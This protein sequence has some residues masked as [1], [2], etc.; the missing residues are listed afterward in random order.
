MNKKK[1]GYSLVLGMFLMN[2]LPLISA[3]GFNF[4]SIS[5]GPQDV[6]QI[7]K[8]FTSPFF[9]ALLNTSAYSEFFFA[10]V[11][12]LILVFV[13]VYFILQK[14]EFL[15]LQ[16]QKGILLIITSVISILALRYLPENDLISGILLPYNA[17]GLAITIFLPFLIY[18]FFV[19]KSVPFS[20]GRR[21][22]WIVYL[23]I[24]GVLWAMRSQELSH[25]ANNIYLFG[26]IAAVLALIFDS[27]IHN[28]FQLGELRK[29]ERALSTQSKV[30]LINEL[31]DIQ[32]ALSLAPN[33][34]DLLKRQAD[35]VKV[36]ERYAKSSSGS[37]FNNAGAGI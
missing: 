16:N 37:N 24:F 27:K 26:A 18:F 1:V 25:T 12:L 3:Y 23:V 34:K 35:I 11:L 15:G 29:F 32:R 19:E 17:L 2:I 4:Y 7:V 20:A 6:I 28:Y 13:V 31:Q 36:L 5:Q 14:S 22:A 9:E 8:D 30:K 33:D 10:K 21:I